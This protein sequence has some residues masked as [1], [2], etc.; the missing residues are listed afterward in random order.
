MKTLDA[1]ILAPS[2][3]NGYDVVVVPAQDGKP[4]RVLYAVSYAR[5]TRI[6]ERALVN[7]E[8]QTIVPPEL[9]HD[10]VVDGLSDMPRFVWID[11]GGRMRL[12]LMVRKQQSSGAWLPQPVSPD[13]PF[14][15]DK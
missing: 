3:C 13:L 11:A 5:Q 14:F 4:S 1:F 8:Y 7:G 10:N 15:R 6:V 12:R 9:Q 2:Y